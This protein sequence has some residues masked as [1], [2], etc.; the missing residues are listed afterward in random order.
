ML[1]DPSSNPVAD[2][3]ATPLFVDLDRTL[4]RTNTL[5]ESL[6]GL[7]VN[8]PRSILTVLKALLRGRAAFKDAVASIWTPDARTLPYNMRLLE[9]LKEQKSAGRRIYLVTDANRQVA[10]KIA[11]H[12]QLFEGVIASD[13]THNQSGSRKLDS[14]LAAAGASAFTYAGTDL[15]DLQIWKRAASGIVVNASRPLVRQVE[16]VCRLERSFSTDAARPSTY[17]RAIR[18]RQWVKNLILFL[19]LLPALTRVNAQQVWS[20]VLGFVAFCLCSSSVYIINDLCDLPADRR[21]VSKYKRPFAHGEISLLRG[22]ALALALVSAGLV[23][24]VLISLQ[25]FAVV[26]L[27]LFLTAVYSLGAKRLTLI[28]VFM[29]AA[30]YTIRVYAGAVAAML[31]V[32]FW[33]LA[34][35]MALFTSLAF[36][37]RYAE[38]QYLRRQHQEWTVGRG[39]RSS[40]LELIQLFG[41]GC[42]IV[43]VLILGLYINQYAAQLA[44]RNPLLLG[45]LCPLQLYWIFRVW[46]LAHRGLMDEDPTVFAVRDR[47]SR[48]LLGLVALIVGWAAVGP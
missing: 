19:P 44:F 10:E 30:L 7:L 16:S 34:F 33:M 41:V 14:I 11:A 17:L 31:P 4:A 32:S 27:Y 18:A 12:L 45:L 35:S 26:A 6:C 36:V 1:P 13:A 3:N 37:K 5:H 15:V 48:Y 8:E 29:L 25:F 9:Y 22:A 28:D 20:V 21:H 40:D 46:M 39:Y 2:R 42:G 47:A 43:S 38:L 24:S 23:V